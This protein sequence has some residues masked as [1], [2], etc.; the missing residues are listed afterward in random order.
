[1]YNFRRPKY[2][3]SSGFFSI[4]KCFYGLQDSSIFFGIKLHAVCFLLFVTSDTVAAYSPVA[5]L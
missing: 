1:M 3:R 2:T 5:K 4:F